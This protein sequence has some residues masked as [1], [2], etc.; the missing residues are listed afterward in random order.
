MWL[1]RVTNWGYGT[2]SVNQKRTPIHRLFY[3]ALIGP[4]PEGMVI[5]HI[6]RN[7]LCIN[8]MHLQ[9]VTPSENSALGGL[10]KTHCPQGHLYDEENTYYYGPKNHRQCD[11]CRRAATAKSNE[12]KRVAKNS[13]RVHAT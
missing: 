9:V 3:E 2:A 10:R 1:D 6:C 7:R 12:A 13:E 11:T 8:P 4:I 5:D